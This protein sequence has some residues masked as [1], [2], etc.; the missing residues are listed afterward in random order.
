MAAPLPLPLAPARTVDV[1]PPT[2]AREIVVLFNSS[3][4]AEVANQ[5]KSML[6][7]ATYRVTMADLDA[8]TSQPLV[9][10][11]RKRPALTVVAVGL[12]ASRIARDQFA[13]PVVFAQVFNH[14]ELQVPGRNIRGVAATPPLDLQL[15]EWKKFDPQLHRVGIIVSKANANLIVPA[16]AAGK[17]AAVTVKSEISDSDLATLYLFKRLAPQIDG[18]WLLPDDRI[19]SPAVLR[20]L[21][22]YALSQGVRVCVFSDALLQWGAFMSATPTSTDVARNVRRILDDVTSSSSPTPPG[23]TPLSEMSISVN[24]QVAERL[25]LTMPSPSNSWVVRRQ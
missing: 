9:E 10:A 11:L 13:G 24:R 23:L 15:R 8:A 22:T 19:L 6:P 14:Q 2:P 5:L 7:V 21:L 4:N 18:L 16:E 12:A 25:R 17:S 1:A 3:A 20:D